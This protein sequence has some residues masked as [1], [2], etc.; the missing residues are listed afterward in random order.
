MSRRAPFPIL[1]VATIAFSAS[2]CQRTDTRIASLDPNTGVSFLRPPRWQL[3]SA[4]DATGTP[5]RFIT[6]PKVAAE[7]QPLTVTLIAPVAAASAEAAAQAYLR[8]GAAASASPKARQ[9]TEWSYTDSERLPSRLRL[10]PTGDGRFFGAWS[11]GAEAAMQAQARDLDA[12]FDSM[13]LEEPAKWPEEQFAGLAVRV[14]P[15]WTRG[16]RLSN[17]THAT[18]QFKSPP[19]AVEKGDATVHGFVTLAKEPIPSPGDQDA[20]RK[21]LKERETDIAVRLDSASWPEAPGL[22]RPIGLYERLRSGN[23]LA[24]TRI[25]RWLVA[26]SGT[27]VILTCESNAE[28]HESLLPW[29]ERMASTVR[30]P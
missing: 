25:A 7:T 2:A 27:G 4:V 1:A 15:S 17:A 11:R 10:I 20:L 6:A 29:C 16:S 5:Y 22:G 26:T 13:T 18:M 24:S 30:F 23:T 14:P 28:V 12:F 9:A 3:G 8:G 19:L 21:V